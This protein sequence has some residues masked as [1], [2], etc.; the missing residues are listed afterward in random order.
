MEPTRR[1]P[2]DAA[3]VP[4][5]GAQQLLDDFERAWRN[6][7]PPALEEF[8][9]SIPTNDTRRSLLEELIKVDLEYRW[10]RAADGTATQAGPHLEDYA[11]RFPELGGLDGLSS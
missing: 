9:S 8:L 2:V 3:A 1:P 10:R 6:G 4:D 7:S 5:R 11:R